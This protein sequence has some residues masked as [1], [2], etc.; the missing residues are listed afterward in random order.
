MLPNPT[1]L[2]TWMIVAAFVVSAAS[3]AVS[4]IAAFRTQ[5]R[6]VSLTDQYVRT[7]EFDRHKTDFDKHV[8]RFEREVNKL[9]EDRKMDVREVHRRIDA[10]SSQVSGVASSVDLLNQRMVQIDQKLDR[11]IERSKEHERG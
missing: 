7:D 8:D 1:E 6:Q 3:G 5:R 11:T 9:N 2:G 4:M 10:V